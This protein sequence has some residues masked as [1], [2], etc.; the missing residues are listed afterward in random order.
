[1]NRDNFQSSLSVPWFQGREYRLQE[2]QN[3]S[4]LEA[5]EHLAVRSK[6]R[7]CK[8]LEFKYASSDLS[9]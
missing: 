2:L 8:I 6:A 3:K 1:M 4:P 5:E 7:V 9:S